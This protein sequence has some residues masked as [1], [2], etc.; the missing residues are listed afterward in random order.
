MFDRS[1][2]CGRDKSRFAERREDL[3][4]G[5]EWSETA[6]AAQDENC[7]AACTVSASIRMTSWDGSEPAP[8]CWP[9][10]ASECVSTV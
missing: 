8:G 9:D 1:I 5:I 6:S 3:G 7:G 10:G 2:E 4:N